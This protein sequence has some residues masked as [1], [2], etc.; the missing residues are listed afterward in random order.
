MAGLM[1]YGLV[2]FAEGFVDYR[3]LAE[4]RDFRCP[5]DV[6]QSGQ[7]IVLYHRPEQYVGAE[8]RRLG[9]D[10][11]QHPGG[12]NDFILHQKFR[13]AAIHSPVYRNPS[14]VAQRK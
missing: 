13:A 7:K 5:A 4:V 9:C 12:R 10:P 14:S 11:A 2:A 1:E 6:S 8:L 3:P